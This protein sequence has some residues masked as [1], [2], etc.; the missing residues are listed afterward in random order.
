MARMNVNI[1]LTSIARLEVNNLALKF[2]LGQSEFMRHAVEKAFETDDAIANLRKRIEIEKRTPRHARGYSLNS[3]CTVGFSAETALKI[4]N[5][6]RS[7][8]VR[9]GLV[10]R[11]A[12]MTA[13][14]SK[15]DMYI[16]PERVVGKLARLLAEVKHEPHKADDMALTMD[17]WTRNGG[18]SEGWPLQLFELA[19][20]MQR[21][22]GTVLAWIAASVTQEMTNVR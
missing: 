11:A 5:M 1:T 18:K 17:Q 8:D 16:P 14:E 13:L 7:H 3:N 22:V 4:E 19:A 20:Y 15:H 6:A 2:G 10:C 21:D 9:F 12:V